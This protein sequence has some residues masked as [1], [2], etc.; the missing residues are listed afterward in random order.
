MTRQTHIGVLK[1]LALLGAITN[2]IELSSHELASQ[3]GVSQQTASRTLIELEDRGFLQRRMGIKKQQMII[4]ERG[5]DALRQEY[6][7]YQRIFEIK[8]KLYI[9][10][11]LVAGLGEGQY[12]ISKD[13]YMK[14]FIEK[15]G[16]AP[17]PGTLNLGI[18][19][20]ETNKL[21]MLRNEKGTRI[22]E[23]TAEGRT[24]GAVTCFKGMI[25]NY[26]CAV[27]LP[28][29]SHHSNVLEVIS[30]HHLRK[31]LD[32]HDGSIVE[33]MISLR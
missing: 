30:E 17:Y 11:E 15:L 19:D 7:A 28:L 22:D 13:G 10:G 1:R 5:V 31:E 24:F 25:K 27:L 6:V 16:F 18:C 32:L 29:R 4:T 3:I 20:L 21:R 33:L 8:D 9:S 26:E 23:F 2:F 12:Y 14:Q